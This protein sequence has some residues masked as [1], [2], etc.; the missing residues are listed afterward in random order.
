MPVSELVAVAGQPRDVLEACAAELRALIAAADAAATADGWPDERKRPRRRF[1][2]A[3]LEH[4]E[5]ALE[6]L[7]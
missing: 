6:A 1:L 2:V 5:Q 4:V 3:Q 7:P